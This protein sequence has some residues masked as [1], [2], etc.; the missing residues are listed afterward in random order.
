MQLLTELNPYRIR[1]F[2]LN[3]I[4]SAERWIFLSPKF[5]IMNI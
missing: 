4:E 1:R 2:L 5:I 3:Q